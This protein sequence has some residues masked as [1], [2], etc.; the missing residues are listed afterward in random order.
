MFARSNTATAAT[1]T[2]TA[3]QPAIKAAV[4]ALCALVVVVVVA[5]PPG[6]GKSRLVRE[7]AATARRQ[8]V[9]VFSVFCESHTSQAPFHAVARPIGSN[10]G[11][12][13]R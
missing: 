6:I 10:P 3:S 11:L 2:T 13:F 5:G 9:E 8:G 1:S 7:V 12:G 4:I